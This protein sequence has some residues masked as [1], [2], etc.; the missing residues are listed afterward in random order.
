M[1]ASINRSVLRRV[2]HAIEQTSGT[3]RDF[4][5]TLETRLAD[6]LKLGRIGRMRLGICLEE[7]F[8][9]ELLDEVLE[10]AVTVADIVKY[11]SRYYYSDVGLSCLAEQSEV[12]P[13]PNRFWSG[14]EDW[15]WRIWGQRATTDH[16]VRATSHAP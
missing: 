8:S 16:G 13:G 1:E 4:E 5:V 12:T 11:F 7:V 6:D 2:A 9:T 15:L 10:R 14:A 3:C